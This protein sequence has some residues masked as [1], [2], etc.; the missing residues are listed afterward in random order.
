MKRLISTSTLLLAIF[1]MVT[2]ISCNAQAPKADLKTEIDS[3]SY[4]S[5]VNMTQGLSQYLQQMGIEEEQMDDF[6]AGFIEG[7]SIDK[8]DKKTLARI[9]GMQIGQQV[10]NQMFSN[11]ERQIFGEDS[12]KTLSKSNYVAGFIT[13]V[14]ADSL[15]L[16]KAEDA[17]MYAQTVGQRIR[18]E[19]FEKQ[20][21]QDKADNAKFLEDNKSKE[22]IVSLPSGLQYKVITE[23]KGPKP[24]ATD[25][26]LVDYKGTTI[27]GTEFDSSAKNGKPVELALNRVIKGW[28]EGIQLMPVGSKYIFYIPY[29]L[30]Y[31]EQGSQGRIPPYATLIFEVELHEIVKQ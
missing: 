11:M 10:A 16:I 12:T 1:A 25:A 15:L 28:T 26:V 3:L 2:L 9:N 31:G 18:M 30:A 5:G 24:T 27:D 22:G 14:K 6:I 13:A 4:A 8:D 20:H 7:S 17:Q 21:A 23:G 19:E 29:D